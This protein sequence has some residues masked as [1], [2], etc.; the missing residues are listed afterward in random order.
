[1][2]TMNLDDALESAFALRDQR[3]LQE[4]HD[5][6]SEILD[7]DS[8]RTIAEINRELLLSEIFV[9]KALQAGR[10]CAPRKTTNLLSIG[11]PVFDRHAEVRQLIC[12]LCY[13][14][15][16][17]QEFID[18]Y[19]HDNSRNPNNEDLVR[20]LGP[21]FPFLKYKR[22]H[23]NVGP[24]LNIVSLYLEGNSEFQWIIGDDDLLMPGSI[25]YV[26]DTIKT[27]RNDKVSNIYLNPINI[28]FPVRTVKAQRLHHPPSEEE[29]FLLNGDES[30]HVIGFEY[31]RVSSQ[32][33]RR[34]PLSLQAQRFA[35]GYFISP[36][37]IS[38]NAACDGKSC[39]V[40]RPIMAYRDG[41]KSAWDRY[42]L[43]V[44][45]YSAPRLFGNMAWSGQMDAK[46]LDILATNNPAIFANW[47]NKVDAIVQSKALQGEKRSAVLEA[48]L[49][50]TLS[51]EAGTNAKTSI[52]IL[53]YR[54]AFR[55]ES[56]NVP[57]HDYF[58]LSDDALFMNPTWGH[59]EIACR[60][61][62][63][64][65][66]GT[67]RLSCGLA[68]KAEA[69]HAVDFIVRWRESDGDGAFKESQFRLEPGA[70]T[71]AV[72]DIAT[73][74]IYIDLEFSVTMAP[75][76]PN[77]YNAWCTFQPITLSCFL[78][79]TEKPREEREGICVGESPS[80][81][82]PGDSSGYF[83][84][85]CHGTF[86]SIGPNGEIMQSKSVNGHSSARAI[87]HNDLPHVAIDS[88]V[89]LNECTINHGPLH[90]YKVSV[91]KSGKEFS[92]SKN[93]NFLCAEADQ[94]AVTRNRENA[95]LW[96]TFQLIE[97]K[98][99]SHLPL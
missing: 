56:R 71:D 95:G 39:Y 30:V 3:R 84:Q 26:M 24:D 87:T 61:H 22:H 32:I 59:E 35:L 96:E 29:R 76:A 2:E 14:I 67:S 75:G 5:R 18:V 33:V 9:E 89:L 88:E 94:S 80:N 63:I 16:G 81:P 48:V 15:S 46:A 60:F 69:A 31:L 58:K 99:T 40:N 90:G 82:V 11:V 28:D 10:P 21:I 85:T 4:A 68:L 93:G 27:Y 92:L 72:T 77:N 45:Y 49:E 20:E 57:Q 65:T 47:R 62:G 74:S 23:N 86:L 42:A 55:P 37:A 73:D 8:G 53:K 70:A 91:H 6:F 97:R 13:Q 51:K 34:K 43:E 36:L 78:E 50:A 19:I 44:Y 7:R 1:M 25:S 64:P 38:L 83:I 52:D 17:L 66:Y 98:P 41:D 54:D 12:E 79:E